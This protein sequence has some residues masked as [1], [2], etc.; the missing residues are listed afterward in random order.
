MVTSL[1]PAGFHDPTSQNKVV[2]GSCAPDFHPP[3]LETRSPGLQ[4]TVSTSPQAPVEER[5]R[6]PGQH[7]GEGQKRLGVAWP[8][9]SWS[10]MYCKMSIS[11]MAWTCCRRPAT[12]SGGPALG[13]TAGFLGSAGLAATGGSGLGW[14]WALV[15]APRFRI[16]SKSSSTL[17]NQ[18]E[19]P[20]LTSCKASELWASAPP[21]QPSSFFL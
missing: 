19:T 13:G 1:N 12:A 9:A 15:S 10:R 5:G 4:G 17:G 14:G 8:G 21:S 6:W 20:E 3:S 11:S 18:R 2:Q 16:W 7:R